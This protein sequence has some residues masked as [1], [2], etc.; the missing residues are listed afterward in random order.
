MDGRNEEELSRLAEALQS[1]NADNISLH[2]RLVRARTMFQASFEIISSRY[3]HR[4]VVVFGLVVDP[5]VHQFHVKYIQSGRERTQSFYYD[6]EPDVENWITLVFADNT[7]WVYVNCSR[8]YD[9]II[10]AVDVRIKGYNSYDIRFST[11]PHGSARLVVSY[12]TS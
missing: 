9:R 4:D 1:R 11:R 12:Q 3:G 10:G 6:F 2:L 7:L 8:I 5:Q